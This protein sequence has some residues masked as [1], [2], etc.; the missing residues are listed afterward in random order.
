MTEVGPL[1]AAMQIGIRTGEDAE[2]QVWKLR[3]QLE[4]LQSSLR[5]IDIGNVPLYIPR[6]EQALDNLH[7]VYGIL[8][9]IRTELSNLKNQL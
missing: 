1:K 4:M 6:V 7:T 3:G 8:V 5:R 2:D 9:D